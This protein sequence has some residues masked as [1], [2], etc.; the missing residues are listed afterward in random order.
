MES[1][2]R[3]S[4]EGGRGMEEKRVDQSG[5]EEDCK[6]EIVLKASSM[7]QRE[8]SSREPN[9][10]ASSL[11]QKN[12]D[13][14]LESAKAQMSEVREENQRLRNYLNRIM[15]DYQNLQMQF[16]DIVQ[17]ESKESTNPSHSQE[18][19]T[20]ELVSLSL[21]RT[22]SSDQRKE[23]K[24]TKVKEDQINK[25]R[26]ALGLGSTFETSKSTGATETSPKPSPENS[27]E[28]KEEGG[29]S[30][31]AQKTLKTARSED[32]EVS[33]QNPVK[34]ARVSVRVRCDTPTMN[35]GCQWRKYGQKIAKGN[36]CP[37]AY[38]RCTVA[39]SCP[40]R[41]QVQ[42]CAE[43]MS[44][45]ITTYE[46]THNHP[47]SVSA[48][49]MAS[50]TSAAASMLLS[51]SSTSAAMSVPASSSAAPTTSSAANFGGFNFYLSNPASTS[52]KPFYLPYSSIQPSPSNP[53]ITLDLTTSSPSNR[54]I[55]SASN[56]HN[57]RLNSSTNLN[58][59]SLESN[60]LPLSWS[61]NRSQTP[62]SLTFARQPHDS[63]YQS[64]MQKPTNPNPNA[65]P[66]HQSDTIAAATKAITSD[67]SFQ[68][69][70]AAALKSIIGNGGGGAGNGGYQTMGGDRFG[71][72]LKL[73][74]MGF[75][76][77]PLP[78]SASKTKSTG[79]TD[80][81]L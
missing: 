43:D 62:S 67:P 77:P 59:S 27:L 68:S 75:L 9:S 65:N 10:G 7:M 31:A 33:Q 71:Q 36:P 16:H 26:L 24:P 73:G 49:A 38:Y 57:S 20:E 29:E 81:V 5:D 53:T 32:D 79:D 47:L 44:I 11:V 19:E 34:R 58:F 15:K 25:E 54:I 42:R 52:S 35:D 40:V 69:A 64:F 14:K 76:Q 23:E 39:P 37:R 46:G 17:K 22:L 66:P 45:L 78:F 56:F 8:G 63:F 72:G 21:G 51:G 6:E 41:K 13:N 12:Q 28:G 3:K 74:S 18:E 2:Q 80:R 60:P 55:S 50:T 4:G 70:L 48:T 30:W 1:D 61:N